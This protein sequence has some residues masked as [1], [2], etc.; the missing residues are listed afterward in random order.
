MTAVETSRL[1]DTRLARTFAEAQREGRSVMMPFLT[2]GWPELGDTER[3]IPALIEGGADLI[4]IGI[5]F[6]DPIA[7]GPTIQ[8][9]SQK[10]LENGFTPEM[11]FQ[12]VRRLR[13]ERGVE[14]PLL[15][16]GYYNPILA[17]G[18]DKYVQQCAEIGVDGLIVPDLP[19]EE[20]DP[21]LEACVAN[22]VHLIYLLAPTSTPE[23]VE[24]VLERANGFIYLVALIGVTGARDRLWEGFADYVA[25]MRGYT[26][27]PLAVGF[28]ISTREHVLKVEKLADGVIYASA[29]LDHLDRASPD[30]LPEEA[31][32]FVRHL[33]GG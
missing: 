31:A 15:F 2:A 30:R 3:L 4:E 11:G 33:R 16:M 10:A 13:E 23:R 17:Y 22:G 28:G 29:L 27:L 1:A 5:P 18:I 25:R 20:S 21:L 12:V 9:T 19:P 26:S 6:S 32:N 7:D 8:R 14:A 24:A